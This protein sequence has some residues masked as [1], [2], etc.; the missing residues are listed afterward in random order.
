MKTHI[1]LLLLLAAPLC[2]FAQPIPVEVH[3]GHHYTLYQHTINK[4]FH[5]ESKFG[6]VHIANV[7]AWYN[8]NPEKGGM[9]NEVMNQ[10]YVRYN[11][12]PAFSIMAGYFYATVP[13]FGGSVAVQYFKKNKDWL[14]VISPRVDIKKNGSLE[15]FALAEYKP[16]IGRNLKLYSRVQAMSSFGPYDHNRSYQRIRL[17]LEV[18]KFQFGAGLDIDEFGPE[19]MVK[20]NAGLFVRK[21]LF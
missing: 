7:S 12:S 16:S 9:P 15:L 11:V 1:T 6:F 2:L 17:G 3:T 14:F 13:D 21:E 10:G 18:A 5:P 8:R 4:S 19:A 20:Y